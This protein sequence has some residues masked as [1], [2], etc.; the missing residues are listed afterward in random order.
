MGY[1]VLV[2]TT[3]YPSDEKDWSGIFIAK[4][5]G[6]MTK[7]G[8]H[9]KV[10]APSDGGFHGRR[11]IDGIETVRFGY[12]YPRYL[13]R[14]TVGGGGI[15]ENMSKS[16]LARIQIIPLMAVF[17]AKA[18]WYARG[19]E[20]VYANWLGAGIVGAIVRDQNV[21]PMRQK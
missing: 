1:H 18:L 7:K 10:L 4:L 16:V 17:V 8:H 14:L 21:C 13:E 15:P 3:S 20:V 2:L 9:I 6:A 12:F 19:C 11:V 5:L